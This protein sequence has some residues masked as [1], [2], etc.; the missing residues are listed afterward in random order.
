MGI[1][2]N[3]LFTLEGFFLA[4][5]RLGYGPQEGAEPVIVI[6]LE[7]IWSHL[8][9]FCADEEVI[10]GF[11]NWPFTFILSFHYGAFGYIYIIYI[12][13]FDVR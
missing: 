4:S 10:F 2:A 5:L 7:Y 3:I 9:S 1:Q 12:Y 8:R 13:N 6:F 11:A